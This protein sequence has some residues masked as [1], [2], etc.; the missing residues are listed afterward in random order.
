MQQNRLIKTHTSSWC[1]LRLV[2]LAA[3]IP[4]MPQLQGQLIHALAARA[5]RGLNPALVRCDRFT[6]ASA[7]GSG[8][9]A[10]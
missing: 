3:A 2:S 1:K 9:R 7:Q 10:L 5:Q 8:V 4:K 6:A